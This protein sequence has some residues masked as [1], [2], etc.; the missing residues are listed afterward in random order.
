MNN[1]LKA[2]Q[3]RNDVNEDGNDVIKRSHR[4]SA[5]ALDLL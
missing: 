4:A 2:T 5:G 1:I 3:D